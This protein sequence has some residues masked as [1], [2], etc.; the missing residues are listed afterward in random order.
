MRPLP[1]L[2]IPV[3]APL[4]DWATP[5]FDSPDRGIFFSTRLW[6]E[7]LIT[8]A[9]PAGAEAVFATDP[10]RVV[11]LPL[12]RRSGWLSSLTT[13]YSIA[14][15]PL[16]APG[17]TPERVAAA[18]RALA[19]A[20]RG[21]APVTLELLDPDEPLLAPLLAGL[22]AGRVRAAPFAQAGNWHETLAEGEGWEAYL[23]ARDPALRNT[24]RRK[25]ARA[26]RSFRLVVA[27]APGPGL[28][29][30]IV[31]YETVRAASWKPHEPVPGF[32]AALL[33]AAAPVGLVRIG[34][35]HRRDDDRPVAAQYWI[36]DHAPGAGGALRRAT[37]LKLA[38]DEAERSAS[39]GTVL[40]ALMIR[41]LIEE[42]GVRVLDFGR[43]DDPYKRLWVGSRRQR[44]G[45]VLADPLS[46]LGL[47]ALGRQWAGA[48]LRRLRRRLTAPSPAPAAR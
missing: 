7:T 3:G 20:L 44:I 10:D 14:W 25:L 27:D 39:P 12:L 41:R 4:P 18:G 16:V 17:A 36:L 30:A 43:G 15:R 45:L 31:A 22:R 1:T 8:H 24:I 23:A 38:H 21:G 47:A 5:L 6:Y 33:R 13:I 34:V 26:E 42:D 28:E 35:L 40:T 32:D 37:V 9:L 48:L 2:L 29:A 11:L 19:R 46:P